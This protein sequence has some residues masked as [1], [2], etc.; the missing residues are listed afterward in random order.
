[1]NI[2]EI[3]PTE[4]ICTH[5][6]L[7]KP[8]QTNGGTGYATNEAGNKIC[9]DCCALQDS[10]ELEQMTLGSKTVLYWDGKEISNWPGTLRIAAYANQTGDHNIAKTMVTVWFKHQGNCYIGKNY[11][12]YSQILHVRRVKNTF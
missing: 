10:K 5:C 7:T 12:F 1:M 2:I 4:F 9:Y 6:D 11:G 8:V 3:K